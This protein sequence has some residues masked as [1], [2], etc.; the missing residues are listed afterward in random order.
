ML[1]LILLIL[2]ISALF[3]FLTTLKRNNY[4]KNRGIPGPEPLPF[5]GN[6]DLIFG[7]NP[8]ALQLQR[9]SKIY[10]NIYGI[11]NGWIN[12]LIISEPVMVKEL[13]VDKFDKFYGRAMSPLVGDVE[14][15]KL[16]HLFAAKG[17]RWKR[18]RA[19]ANPAFSISNLKRVMPIMN[20]SIKINIQLLKEAQINEKYIDLNKY[21][22]ELTFDI[23]SRIAMGQKESKQFKSEFCQ[24]SQDAFIRFN[25]NIFDYIS[26][27]F[28]WLGRNIIGPFVTA[29]G[30]LRND[31]IEILIKNI[32]EAVKQRK[33]EKIKLK[34][35]ENNQWTDFI[36]LFLESENNNIELKA[37]NG[38]Y[39]K[40]EKFERCNI[41]EE[42]VLNCFLFLLAGFDTTANTLSLI[43]HNLVMYPNVQK[44]LYEEIEEICGLE[45]GEIPTYEQLNKLKYLDAIFNETQR[46]CPIAAAVVNRVC[47]ETTTLGNI[48]IEKGTAISV[49]LFTLHRN[50]N[51]WGED[52][53]QFK[54][55][56]WLNEEGNK[57]K[58][59]A[60]YPF[61]GGPRICIGMRLGIMEA[62]MILVQLLRTFELKR[63]S[64][65]KIELDLS[66]QV[67]LNPGRITVELILRK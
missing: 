12:Q 24:I 57:I 46:L 35:E 40:T 49:D 53:E 66:G 38:I 1:I 44:K 28:P 63:C 48:T 50:K 26:F 4:W 13:L 19:I 14:T 18:L 23:I 31:P 67:V 10:G 34:N 55:E 39:K 52:S 54:P 11:K 43:S 42:I 47:E 60:F 9:W 51:I 21:I 45:E 29:T 25:N 32:E 8:L 27:I 2:L 30:K 17:K 64:E 56:R 37:D 41:I 62:K 5:K 65:T 16:V 58:N 33:E 15:K 22:T 7:K 61:G 6:I 20:D 36:D 3:L 59:L